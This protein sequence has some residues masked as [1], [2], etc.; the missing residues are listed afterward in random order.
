MIKTLPA[1]AVGA[2]LAAAG[3]ASANHIDLFTEGDFLLVLTPPGP[4]VSASVTE[5]N[6][7]F[8]DSILGNNRFV[9]LE[10]TPGPPNG[11][12]LASQLDLNNGVLT[13]TNSAETWGTMTLRYGDTSDLDLVTASNYGALRVNVTALGAGDAFTLNVIATDTSNNTD[14]ESVVVNAT[15]DYDFN[16][17]AFAG[18]DF[19]SIDS[20]TFR[21]VSQN[22]GDDITLGEIARVVVPEPASAGLLALGGLALL[23]RRR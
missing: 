4:S 18:V 8:G 17:S 11:I 1:L 7:P 12:G 23:R 9:Q 14:T 21:V 5:E 13:Y 20:L 6:A 22:P 15:G 16:F 2:A 3:V 10:F 19:T